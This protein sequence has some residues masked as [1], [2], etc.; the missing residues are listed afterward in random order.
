MAEAVAFKPISGYDEEVAKTYVNKKDYFPSYYEW[1]S[2]KGQ[3]IN[4]I[5]STPAGGTTTIYSVPEDYILFITSAY[6]S[7]SAG[8]GGD[9]NSDISIAGNVA[10][11]LNCVCATSNNNSL[12]IN[13][14]IPLKIYGADV[15]KTGGNINNSSGVAGIS[16][17][18][19]KKDLI[20]G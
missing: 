15:I 1:L 16:G 14:S 8:V 19:V 7:L 12:V 13:F 20:Y 6:L 11:V 10:T 5:A 9:G 17:F 2:T 3:L 18:L 4:K